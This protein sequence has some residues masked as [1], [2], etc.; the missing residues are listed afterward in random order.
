MR[1][2]E[3]QEH[4]WYCAKHGMYASLFDKAEADAAERGA[5]QELP[6]G[7]TGIVVGK[8]DERQG[9]VL[10]YLREA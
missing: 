8:G 3:G 4:L 10:L 6:N 5:D 9:G 7:V 2:V 1:P